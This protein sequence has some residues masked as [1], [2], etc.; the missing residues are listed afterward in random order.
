MHVEK[1]LHL[2]SILSPSLFLPSSHE[3]VTRNSKYTK[4]KMLLRLWLKC[5]LN[6]DSFKIPLMVMAGNY[7]SFSLSL[8]LFASTPMKRW[9][10]YIIHRKKNSISTR[11]PS[12]FMSLFPQV[13]GLL[14]VIPKFGKGH[15]K[16][17][18][19]EQLTGHFT[20]PQLRNFFTYKNIVKEK[21]H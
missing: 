7:C 15:R 14:W 3:I 9:R 13:K 11:A 20:L 5:K 16:G 18:L 21:P 6:F 19:W 12:V 17:S 10:C 8:F 2:T 4:Q 1:R